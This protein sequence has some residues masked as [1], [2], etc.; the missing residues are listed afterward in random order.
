MVGTTQHFPCKMPKFQFPNWES[1]PFMPCHGVHGVHGLRS[2]QQRGAAGD[3]GARQA[4]PFSDFWGFEAKDLTIMLL[5]QCHKP[6][7]WK[8]FIPPVYGDD[9]RMIY[10]C[11]TNISGN[12]RM[13]IE[14]TSKLQK[15]QGRVVLSKK[16]PRPNRQTC[17]NKFGDVA[18]II[19]WEPSKSYSSCQSDYRW[20]FFL[21]CCWFHVGFYMLLPGTLF[22]IDSCW[23]VRTNLG[24]TFSGAPLEKYFLCIE[25]KEILVSWSFCMEHVSQD[26]CICN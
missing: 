18:S 10:F 20:S 16:T 1:F 19:D 13:E 9:W 25:N 5:K 14:E 11:F 3:G 23:F 12:E 17:S 7:I 2:S 4:A 21:I 22:P 15:H 6:P 8:W 24:L 26:A